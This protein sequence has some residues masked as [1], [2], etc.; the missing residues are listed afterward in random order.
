MTMIQEPAMRPRGRH[1]RPQTPS[2]PPTPVP[3][4]RSAATDARVWPQHEPPVSRYRPPDEVETAVLPRLAPVDTAPAGAAG[5]SAE[6]PAEAHRRL[7]AAVER[8]VADID[9]MLHRLP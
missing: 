2:M 6:V 3:Q 8:A 9:A 1:A 7:I 5:P 4:Q